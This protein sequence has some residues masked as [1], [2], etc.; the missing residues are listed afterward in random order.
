MNLHT[1]DRLFK[2]NVSNGR[3]VFRTLAGPVRSLAPADELNHYVSHA[4]EG[5]GYRGMMG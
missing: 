1:I 4:I 3:G 5:L 2:C